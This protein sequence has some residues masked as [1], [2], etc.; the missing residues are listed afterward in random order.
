MRRESRERD[1][2]RLTSDRIVAYALR[3][4]DENGIDSFSMR[5]VAA[6]L[7]V[8]S[9]A[10]YWHV[11]DREELLGRVLTL[12]VGAVE[13]PASGKWDERILRLLERVR[14]QWRAHP[15]VIPL[16]A[17][18]DLRETG[19]ARVI[20]ELLLLLF[21]GG[22]RGREAVKAL[23][24]LLNHLTGSL[25]SEAGRQAYEAQDPGRHAS[26]SALAD[27]APEAHR[28]AVREAAAAFAEPVD[29]EALFSEGIRAVLRGL[30]PKG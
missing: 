3:Q 8:T 19:T 14:H 6:E 26:L 11:K 2:E 10:L 21:E 9:M 5:K 22:Y 12:V 29:E 28:G 7:G 25:L 30:P 1:R 24:L 4:I 15:N 16:L 18:R 13:V 27:S 20:D 17:S 23:R